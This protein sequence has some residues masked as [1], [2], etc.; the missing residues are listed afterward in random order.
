MANETRFIR[1][2]IDSGRTGV[3]FTVAHDAESDAITYT[4][5]SG[6]LPSGLSLTSTSSGAVISG[7]ANAQSSNTTSTFTLRATAGSKTSD[8]QYTITVNAPVQQSFTSSGTFSVPSGLTTV[9]VLVVAGG[10]SGGSDNG[11]GG[12]GG[13]IYRL[14]FTVTPGGTVTVT[15]GDGG[16]AD[17][18]L[19]K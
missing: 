12:A 3:S 1:Y 18:H 11:G 17:V 2:S 13:L 16:T 14:G 8:R 6:S 9:N 5:Q 19:T 4:L 7:N 15:V 10:G